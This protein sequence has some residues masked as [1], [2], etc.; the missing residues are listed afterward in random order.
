MRS[1][2][3]SDLV[4]GYIILLNK[5]Y[6]HQFPRINSFV[7]YSLRVVNL[8]QLYIRVANATRQDHAVE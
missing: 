5:L 7:Y 8:A 3:Q 6:V 4:I 2:I 1:A